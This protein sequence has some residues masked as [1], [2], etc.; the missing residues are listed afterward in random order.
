MYQ[1][2]FLY[3]ICPAFNSKSTTYI[4][5]KFQQRLAR[6]KQQCELIDYLGHTMSWGYIEPLERP[7]DF[8]E[9]MNTFLALSQ[10]SDATTSL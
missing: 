8:K 10:T 3:V 5:G 7:A 4:R 9:R 1:L 6:F 2:M